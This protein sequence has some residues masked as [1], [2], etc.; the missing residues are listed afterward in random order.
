MELLGQRCTILRIRFM[1]GLGHQTIIDYPYNGFGFKPFSYYFEKHRPLSSNHH[2]WP[3]DFN[4]RGGCYNGLVL[5][6][7]IAQVKFS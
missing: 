3:M 5:P 7:F 1:A 6:L 4:P 2:Y